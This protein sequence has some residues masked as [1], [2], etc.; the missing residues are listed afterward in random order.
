MK[1]IPV[2]DIMNGIV[3]HAVKGIRGNYKPL[4]SILCNSTEPL[5]VA[6]TFKDIGFS[7]LYLADLDAIINDKLDL[8]MLKVI[9][10]ETEL[11]LMV[12]AGV[13]DVEITKKLF[14][15]GVQRTVIGTETLEKKDFL[16]QAVTLFGSDRIILSLDLRGNEVLFKWASGQSNKATLLL[17]EFSKMGL[18]DAIIL[19]LARVGSNEG[20]DID[21]LKKLLRASSLNLYVGGGIR[22]ISEVLKL[23]ELGV[24]GVLVASALHS[25]K[26]SFYDLKQASL[27]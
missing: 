27:L 23:E 26:I 4:K 15:S 19:D 17:Q 9:A 12:D 11:R 8:E 1:V 7:E 21:F 16:S 14:D 3:V 24:S 22:S 13:T 20:V 6:K 5:K 10:K 25:G 18:S 2:I